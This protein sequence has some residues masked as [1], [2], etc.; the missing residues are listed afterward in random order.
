MSTASA[1]REREDA[2]LAVA[3]AELAVGRA[4]SFVFETVNDVWDTVAR[5][6]E[7]APRQRALLQLACSGA[8]DASVDAVQKVVGAAGASACAD[9]P[10]GKY[11]DAASS[12]LA[13]SRAVCLRSACPVA[14]TAAGGDGSV[15][16]AYDNTATFG[17]LGSD[18]YKWFGGV[19]APNGHIYGIPSGSAAVLKI[20]P[21]T[22]TATTFGSRV[23]GERKWEGGVMLKILWEDI[24]FAAAQEAHEKA[25]R[26]V[27]GEGL[28]L[29]H[30]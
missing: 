21:E 3:E 18:S 28:S 29:I 11:T 15:G 5:G 14:G 7:P 20:D 26:I 4:R 8:C 30:I 16:A 1:L 2:Q 17:S 27:R 22:D 19:L 13:V 9:C 10:A 6:D 24:D 23:S 25:R 12:G